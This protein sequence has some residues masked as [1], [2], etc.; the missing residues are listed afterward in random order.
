MSEPKVRKVSSFRWT[1]SARAVALALAQG[2]TQADAAKAGDI[3]DRTIRRW[4]QEPEFSTEV[5]RLTLITD[6]A[7]RAERVRIAKRAVEL[8]MIGGHPFT[9]KDLLDWLK[10]IQSE[11]DGANVN[12]NI[13][14]YLQTVAQQYGIDPD[15]LLR[16][17]EEIA[18]NARR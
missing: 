18:A 11:T 2:K 13:K 14:D 7:S 3:A 4:L 8:R 17:A 10:Y 5:D 1:E 6:Y 9:K 16:R 12:V 15:A